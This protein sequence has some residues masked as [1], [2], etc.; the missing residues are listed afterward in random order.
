MRLKC[1]SESSLK[2]LRCASFVDVSPFD[3]VKTACLAGLG[4]VGNNNQ[5]ITKDYGSLVFFGVF[6]GFFLV[7]FVLSVSLNVTASID[8]P[9]WDFFLG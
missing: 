1:E 9:K 7:C 8:S 2:S 3:E 6:V 4:A 5:L